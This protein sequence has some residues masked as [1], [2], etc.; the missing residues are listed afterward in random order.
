[1][2]GS[3]GIVGK[4]SAEIHKELD[5]NCSF[6]SSPVVLDKWD[7]PFHEALN[8]QKETQTKRRISSQRP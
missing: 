8:K 4:N 1:M 6:A 2:Y 3:D 7:K 5:S